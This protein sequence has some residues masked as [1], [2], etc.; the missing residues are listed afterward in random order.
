MTNPRPVRLQLSRR[1]G[2]NLQTLSFAVNGLSAINVARPTR[3]GNPYKVGG[4][5]IFGS[6]QT[7][8]VVIV[9]FR[10][11]LLEST[12]LDAA[13]YR[14]ALPALRGK[15]LACWC[16]LDAPCHAGVLLELAN[17]PVCE[18]AP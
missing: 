1:K 16:A 18:A 2:F 9:R 14:N 4:E 13:R 11:W 5:T 10:E 3:W 12:W 17:A 6:S 8:D 7:A 15:N